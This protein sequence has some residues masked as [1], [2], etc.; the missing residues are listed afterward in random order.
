MRLHRVLADRITDAAS[1][2]HLLDAAAGADD[3]A[4]HLCPPCRGL[5]DAIGFTCL[6]DIGT[7][8]VVAVS[9]RRRPHFA[10]PHLSWEI[11]RF[12]WHQYGTPRPST[13][14][15]REGPDPAL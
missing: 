5:E 13:F 14:G 3:H 11:A 2:Q 10:R 6:C 7:R 8:G 9:A 1:N 4:G 12:C 15:R